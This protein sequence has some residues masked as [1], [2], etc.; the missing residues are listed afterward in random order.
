MV[1]L[2]YQRFFFSHTLPMIVV[3]LFPLAM[4]WN[5]WIDAFS[6]ALSSYDALGFSLESTQEA[7]K[8]FFLNYYRYALS[9]SCTSFLLSKHLACI[10]TANVMMYLKVCVLAQYLSTVWQCD[11]QQTLSQCMAQLLPKQREQLIF[12]HLVTQWHPPPGSLF[13]QEGSEC[14]K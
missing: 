7:R 9:N 6:C 11:E 10:P 3:H 14:Q 5:K 8:L 2:L 1:T 12:Q 13:D 4:L